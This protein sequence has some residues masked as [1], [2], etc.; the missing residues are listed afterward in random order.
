[1]QIIARQTDLYYRLS[2]SGNISK[3]DCASC[4]RICN[5]MMKTFKTLLLTKRIASLRRVRGADVR[6]GRRK[7]VRV[8]IPNVNLRIHGGVAR[9]GYGRE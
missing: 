5:R 8:W 4:H 3:H 1:M 6:K 9:E 7:E 2:L